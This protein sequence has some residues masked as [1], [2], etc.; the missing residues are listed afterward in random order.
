MAPST[1]DQRLAVAGWAAVVVGA[2]GIP[3]VVDTVAIRRHVETMSR[4]YA[5]AALHP[6]KGPFVIGTTAGVVIGLGWHIAQTIADELRR[7]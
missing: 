4:A 5:R 2:V 6:V 7:H 3:A 1:A